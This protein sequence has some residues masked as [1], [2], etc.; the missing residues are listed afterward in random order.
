MSPVS[1]QIDFHFTSPQKNPACVFY[2]ALRIL[3][4]SANWFSIC[5]HDRTTSCGMTVKNDKNRYISS[6][7]NKNQAVQYISNERNIFGYVHLFACMASSRSWRGLFMSC[8]RI[9]HVSHQICHCTVAYVRSA[10]P[11][12]EK[13]RLI[14]MLVAFSDIYVT[15]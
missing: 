7:Q 5:C 1:T 12:M 9:R 2:Q 11:R 3:P 10:V 8:E 14:L 6:K 15:N 13:T 4:I